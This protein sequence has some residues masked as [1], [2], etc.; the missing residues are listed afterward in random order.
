VVETINFHTDDS[1]LGGRLRYRQRKDGFRTGIEPVLL[2]AAVPAKPGET[3][4]EAGT[5]AGAASLCLASRCD[6]IRIVSVERDPLL[7]RLAGF[8]ARANELA[9]MAPV[10]ADILRLPTVTCFDH[11][12]SNPPW[13]DAESS[14]S[15]VPGRDLAKRA[16]VGALM[17]WVAALA[18]RLRAGGTLTLIVPVAQMDRAIKA[19]LDAQ[20]GAPV[21]FPLWPREGRAAKLVILRAR[22]LRVGSAQ[23]LPGLTLHAAETRYTARARA[24]LDGV[25]AGPIF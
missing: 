19:M 23:L 16:P 10:A 14:A 13:H 17:G 6:S 7:A 22:R 2:A 3:V 25:E 5:G 4:I 15:P 21:I 8:N 18:A 12:M 1:L 24:V 9:H 11:A 20:C